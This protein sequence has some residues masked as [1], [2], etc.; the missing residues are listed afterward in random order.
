MANTPLA[1]G[2]LAL[3]ACSFQ[4][5]PTPPA[6]TQPDGKGGGTFVIR[7]LLDAGVPSS[8]PDAGSKGDAGSADS[9]VPQGNGISY[10][11]GLVLSA[12]PKLYLIWYGKWAGD[13]AENLLVDWAI[14]VGKS[15]YFAT[16]GTYGAAT[17]AHFGGQTFDAYSQGTTLDDVQVGAV[18]TGAISRHAL[19]ED[20]AGVYFVLTSADVA[21]LPAFCTKYCGWHWYLTMSDQKRIHYAF[22]GDAARCPSTC[23]AQWTSPNLDPAADA[24][25]SVMSH[26]LNETVTDP[27]GTG[28]FDSQGQEVG[29]KCAW[30]FGAEQKT[31]QGASYNVSFQAK[32]WLLQENWINDNGGYCAMH[33]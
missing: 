4:I 1:V 24:M 26:E 30:R 13:Y 19:P 3:V 25:A 16:N 21:Q 23:E 12:P 14:G 20:P 27:E 33:L 11:G 22:V 28:W 15:A 8:A 9:G 29:D 6:A 7:S 5:D 31:K 32:N 17:T 2:A 10:H 18:V